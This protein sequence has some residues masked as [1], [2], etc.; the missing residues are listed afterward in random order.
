MPS[1][2]SLVEFT[3]LMEP[4]LEQML[5]FM[6]PLEPMLFQ[7]SQVIKLIFTTVN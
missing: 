1:L 6:V 7:V 5:E 2:I 4:M 3:D